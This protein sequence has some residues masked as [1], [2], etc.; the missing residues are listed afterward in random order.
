[1]Y[2]NIIIATGISHISKCFIECNAVTPLW[3]IIVN[4]HFLVIILDCSG[5]L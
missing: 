5:T 3:C 4:D 2:Y 1:M